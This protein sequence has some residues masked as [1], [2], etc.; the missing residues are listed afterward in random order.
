MCNLYSCV[1]SKDAVRGLVGGVGD[2]EDRAGNFPPLRAIFPDAVAPVVRNTATG[3]EL[4]NMRWGHPSPPNS[5]SKVT[6]NI[7]NAKS[8]WWRS[9][10]APE[11]RCLVPV[12]SFC[13]PDWRMGKHVPTWYALSPDRPLFFFAGCWRPWRGLRG[14]RAEPV[15]GE[16][17]IFAFLT[18][19]P[20][21]DVAPVHPKAMPVLL[22]ERES[23]ETWLNGSTEEALALQRPAPDDTLKIVALGSRED[24]LV[25]EMA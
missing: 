1:R 22:L 14:T 20:N 18:T 10:L 16:H 4:I 15:R 12:T 21:A 9:W 24:G 5:K 2:W 7:R 17:L 25:P 13:E 8:N 6:T 19:E 23:R 3:R 11:Y